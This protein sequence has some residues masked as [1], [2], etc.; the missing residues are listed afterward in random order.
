MDWKH[1]FSPTTINTFRFGAQRNEWKEDSQNPG[2]LDIGFYPDR[3]QGDITVG[4]GVMHA[5]LRINGQ[6]ISNQFRYGD[7]LSMT[8]GRHDLKVGVL[9]TRHQTNDFTIGRGGGNFDFDTVAQ[10]VTGR[11]DFWRGKV[12]PDNPQRGARQTV[13]GFYVQ[14][15]FKWKPNFTVNLGLRYEPS[16]DPTEVNGLLSNFRDPLNDTTGTCANTAPP[17]DCEGPFFKSPSRTNFAPRIGFAWDPFG[18]GRTSIRAGYGIFHETILPYH[19]TGQLRRSEPIAISPT[20][21]DDATLFAQFPDPPVEAG[22]QHSHFEVVLAPG[23]GQVIAVA[24]LIADV[25]A[26]DPQPG[27]HHAF[28]D[29]NI[30]LGSV[31]IKANVQWSRVL[32]ILFPFVPLSTK[33]EGV[34]GGGRKDMLPIHSAVD[35]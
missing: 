12:P 5:G 18:D 22:N 28:S 21:R 24:K 11:P 31:R 14:D 7:D 26:I 32:R 27:M 19:Y 15:D 35:R 3:A 29:R 6:N 34:D 23:H 10:Y 4:E 13:F 30:S 33:A 1:V 9:I 17:F 25:L 2:P 8:R 16:S 20:V